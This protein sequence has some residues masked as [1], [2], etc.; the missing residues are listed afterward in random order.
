MNL[1]LPTTLTWCP[2]AFS[3]RYLRCSCTEQ[4]S[5]AKHTTFLL[6]CFREMPLSPRQSSG[7]TAASQATAGRSR[8]CPLISHYPLCFKSIVNYLQKALFLSSSRSGQHRAS[9]NLPG[10]GIR[11]YAVWKLSSHLCYLLAHQCPSQKLAFHFVLHRHFISSPPHNF[12][13]SCWR[14]DTQQDTN[15]HA[16]FLSVCPSLAKNPVLN[17]RLH[18]WWG[19]G[20]TNGE[21]C[22]HVL[23]L[24]ES[25]GLTH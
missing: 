4:N 15:I 3:L 18:L 20:Q 16:Q 14:K 8:C 11:C 13:F 22:P 21:I 17:K 2:S 1:E 6:G 24:R 10:R 12:H 23:N 25:P 9:R 5:K 7:C 19:E